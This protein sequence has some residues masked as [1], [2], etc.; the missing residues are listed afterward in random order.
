MSAS[1]RDPRPN[2]RAPLTGAL[3]EE[4]P[5]GGSS[6]GTVVDA[7]R[8]P[9]LRFLMQ[10]LWPAFLGAAL[11][12][13]VVFSLVDPLEIDIVL[14]H[15]DGNRELAYTG[16]FVLFWVLHALACALTWLLSTSGRRSDPL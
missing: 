15:L 9:L 8:R 12:V 2:P 4:P 14:H 16:G 6:G 13:G 1:R 11:T 5:R 10:V 7:G 3:S